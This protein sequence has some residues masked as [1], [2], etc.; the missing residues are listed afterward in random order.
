M[1]MIKICEVQLKT[2]FGRFISEVR[3]NVHL[4]QKKNIHQQYYFRCRPKKCWLAAIKDDLR[5]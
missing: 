2:L 4:F 5:T 3:S 1:A